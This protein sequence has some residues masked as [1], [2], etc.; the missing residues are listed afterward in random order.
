MAWSPC[1][2]TGFQD[3]LH[4]VKA[5]QE[6]TESRQLLQT[7]GNK[8]ARIASVQTQ[9]EGT[10]VRGE[11]PSMKQLL[12]V[13]L[14]LA[15]TL[16]T[17]ESG[18]PTDAFMNVSKT[19]GAVDGYARPRLKVRCEDGSLIVS[20]NAIPHYES[21]Q[22][23]PNLL[24]ELN[25]E[26]R[27]TLTPE[28]A[29]K[30]S[31]L[32]L[33]GPSG[34]AING[35]PLFG[36]DEGPVP[37]S[38]FGDPI[39]NAIMD[40]CMGHTA[41]QY[42]FHALIQSCFVTGAKPGDASPISAFGDDGFPVFGPYGCSDA[43]CSEVVEFRSSWEQVRSPE[44]DAWDTYRFV[45]EDGPEYLHRCNGHSAEDHGGEYQY[46]AT[47]NWPYIKGCFSGAPSADAGREEDRQMS[48]SGPGGRGPQVD[49]RPSPEQVAKAAAKL[50]IDEAELAA[51]LGL[52]DGWRYADELPV[53][54]LCLKY[55]LPRPEPGSRCRTPVQSDP[56][57]SRTT[58][59]GAGTARPQTPAKALG[60]SLEGTARRFRQVR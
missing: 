21:V 16:G 53:G 32:P 57:R 46:H 17:D 7:N 43:E 33:L 37:S 12:I 45:P 29:Q 51:A 1:G 19:A 23:T 14:A 60:S 28:L 50:G 42:H 5:L 8:G 10:D 38:R 35:M 26:Y 31:P 9:R 55:E 47:A 18:C 11:P 3:A 56:A 6:L 30:P 34:V 39:Y 58:S 44:P 40:A 27:M 48:G 41:R 15:P 54:R 52:T 24:V 22:I 25:R 36:P 59:A 4:A 13:A 2:A 20:S 49:P